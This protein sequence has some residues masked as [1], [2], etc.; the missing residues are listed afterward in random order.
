MGEG[1]GPP[2]GHEPL[3]DADEAAL[4]Q[5]RST[6]EEHREPSRADAMAAYMRHQ[7]EFFG[8]PAP[9][10]R[11]LAKD[12]VDPYRERDAADQLAMARRLFALDERELHYVATDLLRRGWRRLGP[13]SLP[14]LRELVLS[15]P[16]WD[17]VDPLAHV[18]GVLALNYPELR[19]EMD[20]WIQDRNRWIIRVALLH[21]LSWKADAEPERLFG[22]CLQR[23]D[24]EEFFVQKAMGWAL[25]DLASTYRDEVEA[26]VEQHGEQLSAL[27]VREATKHL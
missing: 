7:F 11:E 6:L 8:L 5:L 15:R 17:T 24:V 2:A 19:D 18:I 22:Y 26:F 9:I 23:G 13:S 14:E 10:R 16:W 1:A 12:F 4:A 27:T 21:Q 25:R 20:R 3:S